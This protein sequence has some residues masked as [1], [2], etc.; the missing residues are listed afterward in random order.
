MT[1]IPRACAPLPSPLVRKMVCGRFSPRDCLSCKAWA[2]VAGDGKLSE[3]ESEQKLRLRVV[4]H[5]GSRHRPRGHDADG[6]QCHGRCRSQRFRDGNRLGPMARDDLHLLHGR[7]GSSRFLFA[8][9]AVGSLPYL[10]L[11]RSLSHRVVVRLPR[12]QLP[13]AH[14]RPRARGARHWRAHAVAAN[15]R[16]DALSR[17]PPWDGD[18]YCGHRPG[19]RA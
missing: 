2:Q 10:V 18:G 1:G 17:E 11:V 19:V 9:E 3:D 6:A 15:D 5:R 7:G 8:A 13:D 14:H 16:H 12:G 4:R